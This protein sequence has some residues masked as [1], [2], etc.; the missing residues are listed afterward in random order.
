MYSVYVV[1]ELGAILAQVVVQACIVVFVVLLSSM[2][3]SG[4]TRAV[5]DPMITVSDIAAA[6]FKFGK[7][8]PEFGF[9]D[10]QKLVV[11]HDMTWKSAPKVV[12]IYRVC[13]T[14]S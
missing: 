11:E 13:M 10:L 7:L 1:S 6:L 5:A 4:A 14:L 8:C 12:H 9:E 2:A 3:A